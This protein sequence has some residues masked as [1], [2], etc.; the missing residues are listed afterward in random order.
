MTDV[1]VE[2]YLDHIQNEIGLSGAFT[3]L[4]IMNM[5][6]GVYRDNLTKA[7][8]SCASFPTGDAKSECMLKF[9]MAAVRKL[10]NDLKKAKSKCSKE[11]KPEKCAIKMNKKIASVQ[12]KW[13][14]LNKQARMMRSRVRTASIAAAKVKRGTK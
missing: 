1:L 13:A 9:K 5:A 7:A 3:V 14:S 12:K 8:R 10:L 11:P 6:Y 2:E 4:A